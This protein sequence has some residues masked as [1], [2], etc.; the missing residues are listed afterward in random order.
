[1]VIPLK[2]QSKMLIQP[3]ARQWWY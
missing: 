3:V 1:M 2:K